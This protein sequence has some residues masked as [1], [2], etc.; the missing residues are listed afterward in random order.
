MVEKIVGW[1]NIR[2][3]ACERRQFCLRPDWN[4]KFHLCPAS[5]YCVFWWRTLNI[6]VGLLAVAMP[7]PLHTVHSPAERPFCV[8]QLLNFANCSQT[9]ASTSNLSTSSES[10]WN[11]DSNGVLSVRK[12]YQLFLHESN[13]FLLQNT[14]LKPLGQRGQVTSKYTRFPWGT[15]IPI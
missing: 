6:N 1:P 9:P 2:T 10:Q 7:S 14:P 13:T 4:F 3:K 11:I 5:R 12:Y 8:C 15:W